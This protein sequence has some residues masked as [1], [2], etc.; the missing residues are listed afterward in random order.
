MNYGEGW[1]PVECLKASQVSWLGR[2]F[3]VALWLPF[4]GLV[5]P[6]TSYG[7]D[8]L[9][10]LMSFEVWLI[11]AGMF[12]VSFV[13]ASIRLSSRLAYAVMVATV[14]TFAVDYLAAPNKFIVLSVFGTM[15]A[16]IWRIEQTFLLV[17]SA[18]LCVFVATTVVRAALREE[19]GIHVSTEHSAIPAA[20]LPRLI[21][22]VLDEHLGIE[23][24]P[25][26]TDHARELKHKLKQFYQHYGFEL[27]GGAYSRYTESINAISNLVNFSQES[28]DRAFVSGD[29]S[30]YRLLENRYFKFLHEQGYQLHVV[31][32]DYLDFC[33]IQD[34][35]LKSCTN[36]SW[37][38]LENVGRLNV[39]VLSKTSMLLALF[40]AKY[41]RYQRV[42]NLYEGS[43]R[44]LLLSYGLPMPVV[45]PESL[46]TRRKLQ[47]SSVN[48]MRAM[49]AVS[50]RI[51][52]LPRGS[53]LFAH[54]LLPHFPYVFQEDCSPR[55]I[56]ESL[57]YMRS[58]P[59]EFRTS[60]GRGLRYHQYLSQV[61]CLYIKLDDLFRRMQ[62][63]GIFS[64]SIIIIHGDHGA[65]LGL[66]FPEVDE[67]GKLTEAD[68]VDALST[69]YAVRIPG[70][71]GSYDPSLHAI[72]DLLIDTLGASLGRAPANPIPRRKP[73][74]Y[75]NAGR[76]KEQMPV[77]LPWQP[78][79][80]PP[81]TADVQ[82]R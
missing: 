66:R 81:S 78:S 2:R 37:Y 29:Q 54:L 70:K 68:Y 21:H 76:R 51:L 14:L 44:P 28:V 25:T 9:Y 3:G 77:E 75:L 80:P 20:S 11:L 5:I 7:T 71:P 55:S 22:L 64:D 40:V 30:F 59:Q 27:Y 47:A 62:S 24:I 67:Q 48:A 16:L 69:L 19:P 58:T 8:R 56:L 45:N 23:G 34:T 38:T 50:K 26:D 63:D 13:M 15:V 33:S 82:R 17:V 57:D 53:M 6:F 41:D 4:L 49:D 32:T 79:Y 35:P 18:F 60:E 43:M 1:S 10:P 36:Y 61:E 31:G 12:L 73:F 39:S 52:Q 46:W 42:L 65:R 74:I 72:D